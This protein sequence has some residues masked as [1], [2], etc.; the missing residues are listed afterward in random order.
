MN[1]AT[2][3]ASLACAAVL[4]GLI[5]SGCAG[6]K[7]HRA[8]VTDR[9]EPYECGTITRLHTYNGVF[10]ASQP[11]PSDFEQ[12]KKGGVKTV[13]NL[14]HHSEIS[15][16]DEAKVI[17]DLG[18][19][20]HNVP[21]NGPDEL[22]DERFDEVR[23][24]LRE[25]ERPIL[26]HCS[27]ANRVG[28]MW[29]A[30]RAVDDGIPVDEALA[31][32]KIV[33]IKSPAY[34]AKARDYIKRKHVTKTPGSAAKTENAGFFFPEGDHVSGKQAFTT[35]QCFACHAVPGEGFRAPWAQPPVPVMLTAQ[36]ALQTREQ[37]AESII[38]PSH[39]IPQNLIN[40]KGG[41]LSR[42]GDYSYAMTVRELIDIVAYI[43]S[44][45]STATNPQEQPGE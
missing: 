45:E 17:S 12:A 8:I 10:L 2:L 40:V 44:L 42:M 18:L 23:K 24:L 20:Y 6:N 26:L 27:S 28:A 33:G 9:M 14:R 29:L 3:T 4:L 22:T 11:N 21:W 38:A 32:A 13:I 35:K 5:I 25:A 16:F 19:A 41:T 43:K 36:T 37:L 30:Y 39:K 15:D 1:R 34:E 31:E 7:E